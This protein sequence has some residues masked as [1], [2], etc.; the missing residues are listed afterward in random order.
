[1]EVVIMEVDITVNDQPT[2]EADG[3]MVGADMVVMDITD[4]KMGKLS[5][6]QYG[7]NIILIFLSGI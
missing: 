6:P 4:R 3:D 7:Q 5:E 1:M 2:M